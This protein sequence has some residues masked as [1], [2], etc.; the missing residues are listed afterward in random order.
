MR[1]G[2][3]ILPNFITS[4]SLFC[5]IFS[6]I[7]AH[8]GRYSQAAFYIIVSAILDGIDGKVARFTNTVTRF[9]LEYDSICDV[10]AF[11]VTPA[12][13]IFSFSLSDFGKFGL[14][15][16]YLYV[17]CGA[18][19]L[20]RFNIQAHTVESRYFCGL[21]IPAA[22]TFLATFIMMLNGRGKVVSFYINIFL[23]FV[24][25]ILAFLMVSNIRYYSFK[26]S[27]LF[28]RKPFYFLVFSLAIFAIFVTRPK[29]VLFLLL[30][31]YI[32]SGPIFHFFIFKRRSYVK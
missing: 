26:E 30:A 16:V 9:G 1:K 24:T 22:A 3:Y 31:F 13:L 32:I 10:V 12:F 5:G 18:L 14:A 6:I 29:E 7:L 28:K 23:L 2:V 17:V 27:S 8:S 15:V 25:L 20:A 4:A 21:P 19:R 11:G